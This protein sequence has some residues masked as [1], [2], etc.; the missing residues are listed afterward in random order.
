VNRTAILVLALALTGCSN[1]KPLVIASHMSDPTMSSHHETTTD[2]IGV[3]A[4]AT[5][6]GVSIEGALG[7]KAHNCAAFKDCPSTPGGM[8]TIKW[9]PK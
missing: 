6:G 1:I 9:S 3:G 4:V 8:A 2:F 7:R 5:F